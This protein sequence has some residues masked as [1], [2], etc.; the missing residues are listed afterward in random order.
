MIPFVKILISN[1]LSAGGLFTGPIHQNPACQFR[2]AGLVLFH[3]R[4]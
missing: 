2:P 3:E 1:L 4:G